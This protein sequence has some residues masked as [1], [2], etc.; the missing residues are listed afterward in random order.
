M[1]K[2]MGD[3]KKLPRGE[4]ADYRRFGDDFN[5]IRQPSWPEHGAEARLPYA[6][7]A[8]AFF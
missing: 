8:A 5:R 7:Q 4:E 6:R 3:A 2:N 1:T